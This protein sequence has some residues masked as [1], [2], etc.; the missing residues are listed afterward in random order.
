MSWGL[1]SSDLV[2]I[3]LLIFLCPVCNSSFSRSCWSMQKNVVVAIWQLAI[4]WLLRLVADHI[5]VGRSAVRAVTVKIYSCTGCSIRV[6]SSLIALCAWVYLP[7]TCTTAWQT[8]GFFKEKVFIHKTTKFIYLDRKFTDENMIGKALSG[9]APVLPIWSLVSE[10]LV[11]LKK[12]KKKW[13]DSC[14][15][16]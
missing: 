9:I 13:C 14:R 11:F 1:G 12:W 4:P 8:S 10:D 6:W 16:Q 5:D 7:I 2:F 15:R 3:F